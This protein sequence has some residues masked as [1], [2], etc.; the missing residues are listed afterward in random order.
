MKFIFVVV[1]ITMS[2]VMAAN[3]EIL[4]KRILSLRD[5]AGDELKMV[6]TI[7]DLSEEQWETLDAC[8]DSVDV[9]SSLSEK[10]KFIY[11]L[12]VCYEEMGI[13]VEYED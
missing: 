12:G 8:M 2:L 9:D 4:D 1:A 11:Q 10:Q 7:F 6:L 3:C 13:I 5:F